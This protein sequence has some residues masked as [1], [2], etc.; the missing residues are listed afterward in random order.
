MAS[1]IACKTNLTEAQKN[2]VA[3]AFISLLKGLTLVLSNAIQCAHNN[4]YPEGPKR[5]EFH[6]EF[7]RNLFLDG[8]MLRKDIVDKN[9]A[10]IKPH[11]GLPEMCPPNPYDK[12]DIQILLILI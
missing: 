11:D 2:N 8:K 3:K 1:K 7:W 10:I 9:G 4:Q 5:N 12:L 6:K